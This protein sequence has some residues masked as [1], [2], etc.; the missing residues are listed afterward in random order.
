MMEGAT[1]QSAGNGVT[2]A[3]IRLRL[4]LLALLVVVGLALALMAPTHR[5]AVSVGDA[6]MLEWSDLVPRG[7]DGATV[8][9]D[10]NL[11]ARSLAAPVSAGPVE[12][13]SLSSAPG[14]ANF[15]TQA[16]LAGER[17]ALSG[18]MTPFSFEDERVSAFL[19]VPYV[20]ACIHVPP[21]PPNQI[22]LVESSEPV[23]VLAMWEPFTAIGTLDVES[24][25]TQLAE[26]GYTMRLERIESF[27]DAPAVERSASGERI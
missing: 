8:P 20:G 14:G 24:R 2:M 11:V 18:Y 10:N 3:S 12:H 13:S 27:A 15:L 17:V 21:P 16:S 25:T 9:T 7:S 1:H 26:V 19:L 4:V 5:V 6:R 22:V 23:P